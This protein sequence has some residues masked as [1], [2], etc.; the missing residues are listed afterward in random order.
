MLLLTLIWL[1]LASC[2]HPKGYT[3]SSRGFKGNVDEWSYPYLFYTEYEDHSATYYVWEYPNI[4]RP[5]ASRDGLG[6]VRNGNLVGKIPPTKS[7]QLL[8]TIHAGRYDERNDPLKPYV[9]LIKHRTGIYQQDGRVYTDN[10]EDGLRWI[11]SQIIAARQDK[12]LAY[13]NSEGKIDRLTLHWQTRFHK[14]IFQPKNDYVFLVLPVFDKIFSWF[15]A[16]DMQYPGARVDMHGHQ[17][18]VQ[19]KHIDEAKVKVERDLIYSLLGALQ[20]KGEKQER[21]EYIMRAEGPNYFVTPIIN[22]LPAVQTFVPPSYSIDLSQFEKPRLKKSSAPPEIIL[23]LG[24]AS[25]KM[26]I[27]TAPPK[28][29]GLLASGL[30]IACIS[31][32]AVL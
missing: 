6:D 5:D 17:N 30:L 8:K 31:L 25:I 1:P 29:L 14:E 28:Y 7:G 32:Y 20:K 9:A 10:P 21:V 11:Y 26:F 4:F 18:K 19:N 2:Y 3:V 12:L 27:E 16:I 23:P 24:L 13:A 15:D 22:R